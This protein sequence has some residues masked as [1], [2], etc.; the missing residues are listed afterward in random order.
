MSDNTTQILAFLI[1]TIFVLLVIGDPDLLDGL[2]HM[3]GVKG[4]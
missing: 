1:V 3:T 4:A 2:I